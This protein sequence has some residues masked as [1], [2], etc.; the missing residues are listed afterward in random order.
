MSS[1]VGALQTQTV[2]ALL[3]AGAEADAK[4]SDGFT[5]LMNV[6]NGGTEI[7]QI[8][9]D[10]GADVN[11]KTDNGRSALLIADEEGHTAIVELLKKAG[12]EECSALMLRR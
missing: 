1:V 4:D 3:D 12:A 10:A 6:T 9:L 8:L 7:V 5:A 11:E 2:K